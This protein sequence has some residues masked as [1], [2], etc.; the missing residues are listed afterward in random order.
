MTVS[1]KF[2]DGTTLS[3]EVDEVIMLLKKLSEVMGER[4]RGTFPFTTTQPSVAKEKAT[5]GE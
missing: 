3:G 4:N 5:S 2:P 1:L